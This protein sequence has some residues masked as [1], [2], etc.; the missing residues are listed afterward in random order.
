MTDIDMIS[1]GVKH[2]FWVVA[3][4]KFLLTGESSPNEK[5]RVL[6]SLHGLT[7]RDSPYGGY[8][9]TKEML[10]L[11]EPAS[12]ATYE[13]FAAANNVGDK[14]KT[15]EILTNRETFDILLRLNPS[16]EKAIRHAS[17]LRER[18]AP[19]AAS[20]PV[21]ATP[22]ASTPAVR[23][24]PPRPDPHGRHLQDWFRKPSARFAKGSAAHPGGEYNVFGV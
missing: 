13:I 11:I 1:V 20:N 19:A 2:S 9:I 17:E 5:L 8:V 7:E 3:I 24:E 12:A 16:I 15:F 14:N 18:S 21:P 23:Y 4:G 22:A 10:A 6:E